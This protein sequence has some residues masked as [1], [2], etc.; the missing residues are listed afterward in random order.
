[1]E[2]GLQRLRVVSERKSRKVTML[3]EQRLFERVRLFCQDA[4]CSMSELSRAALR[5]FLDKHESDSKAGE[6]GRQG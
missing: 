3:W 2:S 1:M 4:D 5:D 6:N